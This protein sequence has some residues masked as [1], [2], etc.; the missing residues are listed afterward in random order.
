MHEET[1]REMK[2]IYSMIHEFCREVMNGKGCPECIL[3]TV[4]VCGE[5]YTLTA[6][7]QAEQV[8][9]EKYKYKK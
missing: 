7:R 2:R 6:L 4:D 5:N 1:R 8:I 9:L 3:N